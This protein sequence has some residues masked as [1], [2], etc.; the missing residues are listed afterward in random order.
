MRDIVKA[1]RHLNV[2]NWSL[3]YEPKNEAEFKEAFGINILNSD[4]APTSFSRDSADFP[5]TWN[6][7]VEADDL[8]ALREVRND[9]LV[10]TDWRALNDLT[11]DSDWKVYRQSLRDIT[12]SYKNLDTV[13][14]PEE[15]LP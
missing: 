6:Q 12:K 9:M 4:G 13:V 11:L 2:S 3:D 15:P 8:I 5:V 7:L 10:K 14:W 1:L